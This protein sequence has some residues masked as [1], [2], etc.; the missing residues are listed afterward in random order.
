ME[1]N[2]MRKHWKLLLILAAGLTAKSAAAQETPR[3]EIS[4]G[5]SYVRANLNTP[6]GCC[7]NMHGGSGSVA[8]N[9]NRWF[10]AVA[11]VGVYHSGNVLG[12]GADLTVVNYLFG[13]RLSYRKHERLTPFAHVLLGGGHAGGTLYTG[14]TTAPGPGPNNAF[15]M[16]A[17]GGLDVKV[18]PHVAVRV[19]QA[20]YLFSKFLN[21]VNDR[22]N[23][24]RLTAGVVFR[25]GSR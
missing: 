6:N 17:G 13:P 9:L 12:S 21:G 1:R 8:F 23:S 7:F 3:V 11:E 4:G 20:D 22:Q 14:T 2:A 10:G 25:L 18:S 5:Y 19:F 16:A 24:F 15:V